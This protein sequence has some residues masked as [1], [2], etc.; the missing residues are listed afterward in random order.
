MGEMCG[1]GR[2]FNSDGRLIFEGKFRD[3]RPEGIG[4][5]YFSDG[6]IYEG[7]YTDGVKS[8]HGKVYGVEG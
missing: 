1:H 8:G 6:K 5:E 2:L 3:S 4:I 7:N